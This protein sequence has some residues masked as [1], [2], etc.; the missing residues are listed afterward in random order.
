[1]DGAGG[2]DGVD[3]LVPTNGGIHVF[4]IKSYSERL[5]PQQRRAIE[6]SAR[7][8]AVQNPDMVAWTLV[9]PLDHTPNERQWM[10]DKL[11]TLTGV[12]V[13]WIGRK[14]LETELS[15]HPDLLRA[16]APG[17][18]ED[19]AFQML[20]E[21]HREAVPPRT[22][23][24]VIERA[25]RL[26]DQSELV[27]PDYHFGVGVAPDA[28][29]VA[30]W[31]KSEDTPPLR[32]QVTF[33]AEAGSPQAAAIEEFLTYGRPTTFEARNIASLDLEMPAGMMGLI[34]GEV[35]AQSLEAI[36][37][38]VQQ[39]ARLDAVDEESG[40]VLGSLSVRFT[41]V[42]SGPRGGTFQA[43][44]D[45]SGFL[46]I[47]VKVAAD[48]A[49]G[50]IEFESQFTP[51]LL[52]GDVLQPL[53]FLNALTRATQLSIT[54]GGQTYPA[55]IPSQARM[56][57][58]TQLVRMA[59]AMERIGL[60]AGAVI[61]IPE[62]WNP[63]DALNIVFWDELL[64]R[65]QAP[66]PSPARLPHEV[67]LESVQRLLT[68]GPL[69]RVVMSGTQQSRL[70]Q[71]FGV[72]LHLPGKIS[73]ETTGLLVANPAELARKCQLD[74]PPQT[75]QV[76]FVADAQTATMFRLSQDPQDV[77]NP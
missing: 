57:D 61:H 25:K 22:V 21:H 54:F 45:R 23:E 73:F 55:R 44:T 62:R 2:D 8:A 76:L 56:V 41:E 46:R 11:A 65:G 24:D 53:R 34:P 74:P 27:D 17:N 37:T 75:L 7:T 14:R 3:V 63:Q 13:A 66:Y 40:R 68:Q 16:Y 52:P 60:G 19:L 72:E 39:D 42:S 30:V 77:S 58:V 38:E 70:A 4:E 35:Y 48:D 29:T 47:V 43:G 36:G 64:A 15:L 10:N 5:K 31:P 49:T 26:V 12:P 33:Q 9:L 51:G 32:G 1:M 6:K 28:V 59:E 20:S 69:P 71:L 67:S 18:V 50:G